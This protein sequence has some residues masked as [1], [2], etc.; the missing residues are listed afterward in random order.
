V[1]NAW[2]LRY[3]APGQL[4]TLEYRRPDGTWVAP[5]M[6]FKGAIELDTFRAFGDRQALM[7]AIGSQAWHFDGTS[8]SN[9]GEWRP[10]SIVRDPDRPGTVW[11]CAN[12]EVVRTDGVYCFSRENVDF[13]ELS[14][15]S[16]VLTTVAPAPLG[17]AWV[18]STDGLFRVDSNTGTHEWF[19]PS[20]SE[21]IGT[22]ITPLSLTPDGRIW[23]TNFSSPGVEASPVW[24]D[25]QSFGTITRQ[26]GLPH[27]QIYDAEAREVPG[28]YELW[29]AC[30]SR[31]IAVLTVDSSQP[32]DVNGDGVVDVLDLT[33]VIL[34]WS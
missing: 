4:Y 9:L 10:G 21:L 25:G 31:G 19:H 14:P 8:W 27:A 26:Q 18:G 30:V 24:Y 23:C 22:Q 15:V 5:P 6:P 3:T 32:A 2:M 17:I 11:A 29:L 20:N 7:V 16:D 13:P 28:G 12:L 1:G 34:A 33:A